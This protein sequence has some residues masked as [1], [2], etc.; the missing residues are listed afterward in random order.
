MPKVGMEPVRRRQIIAAARACIHRD[1]IGQASVHRIAREA[2]IAPA[3]IQHY[4]DDKETLL[5]E[6][7]RAMYREFSAD[8]GRRLALARSPQ[9]RLLAL[10]EAQISAS[11][12]TPEAV[13]TWLAIYSTMRNY[14]LLGRIEQAFDRRFH[15]NLRHALRGM[16]LPAVEAHDIAEELSIFI[17]GLWQ[18]VANPVTFTPKRAQALLYRYLNLRLPGQ[19]LAPPPDDTLRRATDD[20]GLSPEARQFLKDNL[21]VAPA[22]L[23]EAN[24]V[25][26]RQQVAQVYRAEARA[27]VRAFGL[28]L[29]QMDLGG[30]PALRVAPR[31]AAGAPLRIFYLYGG[32]YVTGDPESDLPV[33][34]ALAQRMGLALAAPRYRLAPEHRHP[35]ALKDAL[36]AWKDFCARAGGPVF[37]VGESAGGGLALALAQAARDAGLPMPAAMALLSPWVDLTPDQRLANDGHDPT[38]S[39]Q[40]LRDYARLYAA[41]AA[42]L[43]HPA[44]SPLFGDLAGLPPM[45]LTTGS[46][47]ILCEQVHALRAAVAAAG[48]SVECHDWPG[49]WHVFEFYRALPEAA[50][51]LDRITAF[52]CRHD[53]TAP[54]TEK[55]PG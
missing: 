15:S 55:E 41:P 7:F 43:S 39:R 13:S 38:L 16:G 5:L 45:I 12:L 42:D 30:V 20:A 21:P 3:L 26:M 18:N 48:G 9:E 28:G 31:V 46:R 22:H 49:L 14:P 33:A 54:L 51:S 40:N 52:L 4:F 37:L 35:A 6:T 32:G 11:S 29:A 2:G 10:L 24:V 19:N 53:T 8:I 25:E 1:G 44:I 47:D 17:D 36:A 34:G 27:S 23:S 50:A